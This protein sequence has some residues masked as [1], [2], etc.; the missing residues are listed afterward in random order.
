MNQEPIPTPALRPTLEE[1]RDRFE[2]WRSRKKAGSP[3]PKALWRAAVEQCRDHSHL[4][5]SRALRLNYNDLKERVQG[6]KKVPSLSTGGC[7]EFVELGLEGVPRASECVVEM[8]T[9]NGAKLRMH[10]LGQH[11][12]IDPV[13]LTRVFLR[14]GL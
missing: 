1:V 5:V 10:F 3:I 7:V 9:A 11:R 13:A 2:S 12:G 14:Q 6:P 4:E 8:E